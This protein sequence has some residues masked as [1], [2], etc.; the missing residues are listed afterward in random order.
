M[1]SGYHNGQHRYKTFP[2]L[3][4]TLLDSIGLGCSNIILHMIKSPLCAQLPL[5]MDESEFYL[6]FYTS[7]VF[8][9]WEQGK[10]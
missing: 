5:E 4:K 3:Q 9:V 1:T 10:N 8:Y 6:S 7:A 2:P